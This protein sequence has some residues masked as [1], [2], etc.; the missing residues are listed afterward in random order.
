V[1]GP[2]RKQIAAALLAQIAPT[3]SPFY[4]GNVGR[5][6]RNPEGDAAPGQPGLFLIKP[7]E[8]FDH[9][10]SM[11][12]AKRDLHFLAVIYTDVGGDQTAVPADIIDDLV[13]YVEG[14]LQPDT[15]TGR[16]TLGGLVQSVL[17][18]GDLNFTPGDK[19][20]KGETLIPIRVTIP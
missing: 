8:K 7:H 20:G 19:D 10:K 3:G 1:S 18:D 15:A 4:A 5:R 2:T 13:D 6:L 11:L 17:I 12:P 14:Q 16:Q 9:S